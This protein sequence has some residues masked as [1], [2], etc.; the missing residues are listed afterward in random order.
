VAIAAAALL[1]VAGCGALSTPSSGA[2]SAPAS[3]TATSSPSIAASAS[4]SSAVL[5]GLLTFAADKGSGYQMYTLRPDGT[6][7]MQ[8]TNFDTDATNPRWSPNGERISFSLGHPNGP[9]FCS[10]ELMKADG[11]DI[12]DLTGDRNGCE[13]SGGTFTPDG[14]HIVFGRFD[15]VANHEAIWSMDLTG[16][17]R[18]EITDAGNAAPEVSP[19]GKKLAFVKETDAGKSLGVAN[20]DGSGVQE[21]LPISYDVA[22]KIDWSRDG[23]LIVLTL[24]A[25]NLGKP[26]DI[27]TIKPDGTGLT[28]LT[29]YDSPDLRAYVGGYSPD[30]DF[31]VFRLED[32]GQYGLY[33]MNAD[34]SDVQAILPLSNF[35]PRMIDWGPTA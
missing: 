30:G 28:Y 32:H 29:H 15:D 34:G 4:P 1:L 31:I 10:V 17:D 25:D 7:L 14:A 33:R 26:A 21:L 35:R 6:G 2:P 22:N 19:D 24:Y 11:S 18:H 16:G 8:I 27:A 9:T 3:G 5:H 23:K 13:G 20:L 12:V